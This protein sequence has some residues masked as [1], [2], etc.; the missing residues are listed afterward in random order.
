MNIFKKKNIP[1]PDI[2]TEAQ[3]PGTEEEHSSPPAPNAEA[4]L[5]GLGWYRTQFRRTMQ[6]SLG[7]VVTLFV[8]LTV[9]ALLLLNQPKPQYFAATPDLRLAPM[10]PLDQPLLTQEGLLTWASDTITRS[11]VARTFSNGAKSWKPCDPTL[12]TTPTSPS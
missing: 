12:M 8:C 6:L 10:I 1:L 7:L 9:I 5:G 2:R 11:H 3:S 4:V